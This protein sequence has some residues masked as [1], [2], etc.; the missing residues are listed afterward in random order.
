MSN[1]IH[2]DIEIV[3]FYRIVLGITGFSLLLVTLNHAWYIA[4]FHILIIAGIAYVGWPL[5][6]TIVDDDTIVF[7]NLLRRVK[8]TP[9]S[10]VSVKA[11]GVRDYRAQ[12]RLRNHGDITI[13]YRCRQFES[14]SLLARTIMNIVN[15]APDVKVQPDALKLLQQV[16]NGKTTPLK[17]R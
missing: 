5:S 10:I 3:W 13:G 12:L 16:A 14:S 8:I 6:A 7:K 11:I 17:S 15:Q 1:H 9:V 4:L 2:K